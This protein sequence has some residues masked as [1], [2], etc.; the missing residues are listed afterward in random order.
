VTAIEKEHARPD[1]DGELVLR[2]EVMIEA[3][4]QELFDFR[5][6]INLRRGSNS[7]GG[8]GAKRI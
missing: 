7:A 2:S 5:L 6:A 1:A 3:G 8:I 4:E